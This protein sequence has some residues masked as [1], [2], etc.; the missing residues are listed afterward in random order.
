MQTKATVTFGSGEP[1]EI[2][3]ITIDEPQTNE[4]L[5]RLVGTGICHTDILAQTQA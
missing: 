2:K 3:D 4:V 1:F 5:I